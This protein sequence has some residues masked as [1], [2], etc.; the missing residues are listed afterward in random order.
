MFPNQGVSRY[1][2]PGGVLE[3]KA[4]DAAFLKHLKANL[5]DCI[6]VIERDANAE[7]KEFVHECVDRLIDL[8]EG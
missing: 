2:R 1:S 3:D 6:E 7:D 4:A 8:I 5:P